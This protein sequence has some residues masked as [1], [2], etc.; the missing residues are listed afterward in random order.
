MNK[1]RII[2]ILED[3]EYFVDDDYGGSYQH[4][5]CSQRACTPIGILQILDYI[6][7]LESNR[8]ALKEWLIEQRKYDY[9][10]RIGKQDTSLTDRFDKADGY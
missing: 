1:E 7:K 4:I 8:K 10:R 2:E 6:D 9:D 5:N 3:Y